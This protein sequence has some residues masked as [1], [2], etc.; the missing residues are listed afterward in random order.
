L[1]PGMLEEYERLI[2]AH[3][4]IERGEVL[5]A[6]PLDSAQRAKVA[7]LLEEIG[8]N[9]VRLTSAVEP[10]VLGGMIARVGDRVID[11][12]VRTNLT[13]MRRRIVDRAT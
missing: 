10:R 6:V 9:E 12:S 5:S 11:G 13:E 4:G 3:R 7:S 2:D 8:G 1:A